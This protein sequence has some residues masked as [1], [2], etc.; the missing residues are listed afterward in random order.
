MPDSLAGLLLGLA[1][2]LVQ[3]LATRLLDQSFVDKAI[4]ATAAAFPE[5]EA[6]YGI[7]R[8]WCVSPDFTVLLER[9][10]N[11]GEH[12]VTDDSIIQSFL[13]VTEFYYADETK[14]RARE[15]V[16]AFFAQLSQAAYRAPDT[17]LAA[18]AN[19]QEF[20]FSRIL[21]TRPLVGYH[22]DTDPQDSSTASQNAALT[23][24]IDAAKALLEKHHAPAAR[25]LL[26]PLEAELRN[27]T[28][29]GPL[30]YRVVL[31]LGA[32]ALASRDCT[33]AQSYFMAALVYKQEDFK[34]LANVAQVA[35]FDRRLEDALSYARRAW[36]GAQR[37]SYA[38]AILLRC[39]ELNA[40]GEEVSQLVRDNDWI[41]KD[42][43]CA[44][45]LGEAALSLGDSRI[46]RAYAE[47]SLNAGPRTPHGADLL[48]R[49]L[50][51]EAQ[52]ALN[53]NPPVPWRI[54]SALQEQLQSAEHLFTEAA[55][56][57]DDDPTALA[58]TLSN[59]GSIRMMLGD[60]GSALTDLDRG[61]A[62]DASLDMI[63]SNKGRLLLIERRFNDAITTLEA[64]T[65]DTA[66]GEAQYP[67]AAAYCETGQH[68]KALPILQQL[69]CR[70]TD[71]TRTKI[72]V[73]EPLFRAYRKLGR[74][75]DA[76]LVIAELEPIAPDDIDALTVIAAAKDESGDQQA[77]QDLLQ[78]ALGTA[79]GVQRDRVNLALG[80]FW[81]RHNQF[82]NAAKSYLTLIEQ[83]RITP[84]TSKYLFAA[85]RAG[86][87][88]TALSLCQRIRAGG[89]AVP[90]ITE[91]EV[92]ILEYASDL[93]QARDL[94]IQ[95]AAVV[96]SNAAY[97]VRA[98][99]IM[100]RLGQRDQ[101]AAL[102]NEI[103]QDE[104]DDD[105]ELLLDVARLRTWLGFPQVLPLAYRALAIAYDNPNVHAEYI[106]LVLTRERHEE[107][108]SAS[109]AV[110]I[111]CAVHLRGDH[112]SRV[113]TIVH[114]QHCVALGEIREDNPLAQKLL[115]AR[116]GDTVVLKK[117]PIE[118]LRYEITDIQSKYVHAFQDA[119]TNFSRRFPTHHGISSLQFDP[120]N[121]SKLLSVLDANYKL[122]TDAAQAY[123]SKRLPL[124]VMASLIARTVYDVWDD[125]SRNPDGQILTSLGDPKEVEEQLGILAEATTAAPEL[126]CLLG[127]R[128]AGFLHLLPQC[129]DQLLIAQGLYD[130]LTEQALTL[131]AGPRPA[132]TI[133]GGP[134]GI[135]M[136]EI[137]PAALEQRRQELDDL[138]V[139]I[140]QHTKLSPVMGILEQPGAEYRRTLKAFGMST[141]GVLMLARNAT[142]V[143]CADDVLLRLMAR[144]T[145]STKS[146][147]SQ[148]LLRRMLD[149]GLLSK[150]EY[151][152]A[153]V[154]L[155]MSNYQT[156]FI[157]PDIL[158]WALEEYQL[159]AT[160]EVI[161]L[162]RLY[163][164]PVCEEDV[165]VQAMGELT[166]AMWLRVAFPQSRS[167]VLDLIMDTLMRGRT[168]GVLQKYR[169]QVRARFQLYPSAAAEILGTIDMWQRHRRL[170]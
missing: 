92:N 155:V 146:A 23:A 18:L 74:P 31:N 156:I 78:R 20:L 39:L 50:L 53:A 94:L 44:L 55:A 40:R 17:G 102:L 6:V 105:A 170:Q 28:L 118:E 35:I 27:G 87:Y 29:L 112:E 93:P 73:A 85:V 167:L 163:A 75:A 14:D 107:A 138:R 3:A 10:I 91:F 147:G 25:V 79:E 151:N 148:A 157:S 142:A 68:R 59:R 130:E 22:R 76:E 45:M 54:P 5:V 124:A 137:T 15:L 106:R 139:F 49:A 116:L 128:R 108:D 13:T 110:G 34:A 104:I 12:D 122:S 9:F 145:W 70:T 135:R 165:A 26:E 134:Q 136:Q 125:L 47:H 21:D 52:T 161:R 41:A 43:L 97:R 117:T 152:Q 90:G 88:Q 32:I 56:M 2:P 84:L 65:Q 19:R 81:F 80:D 62:L 150:H 141:A 72:R 36:R 57:L 95:L 67:L 11:Q 111:D 63:R 46:A 127:L 38:T 149:R 86:Q 153:L 140:E 115:G 4:L 100:F 89:A 82:E 77:A 144:D 101:A 51:A 16:L 1:K 96:H 42:P 129:F 168:L 37:D 126:T 169:A 143:L 132:G 83:A 133:Q 99:V 162:F 114:D 30:A 109:L 60:P 121:P 158:Q 98:A 119:L 131:T 160:P 159:S 58:C 8:R 103:S 166:R 64:I 24:R 48:A 154:R 69:W 61:L 71:D 33:T 123:V 113:I 7:L 66:H 120:S 164:G